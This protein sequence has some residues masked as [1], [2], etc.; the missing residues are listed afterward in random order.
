VGEALPD[1]NS[2][3]IASQLPNEANSM[4]SE[5][6]PTTV[7]SDKFQRIDVD[8]RDLLNFRKKEVVQMTLF[9]CELGNANEI[10]TL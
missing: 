4:T 7:G 3:V 6:F 9:N 10:P 1:R 8:I 5:S 2:L